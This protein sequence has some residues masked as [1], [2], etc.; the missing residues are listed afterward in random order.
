MSNIFLLILCMGAVTYLP[1]FLPLF[2]LSRKQLPSWLT[3]W[4]DFIPVAILSSLILP[5][6]VTGGSPRHLDIVKPELVT[7]V[8][9]LIFALKT[10]SLGGTVVVGMGIYWLA[11]RIFN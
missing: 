2:F 7:A 3:M 8:P 11:Q 4:L 1:R 6:L 10:R 9:T 5:A